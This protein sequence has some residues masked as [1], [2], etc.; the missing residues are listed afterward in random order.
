MQ[1]RFEILAAALLLIFAINNSAWSQE[2]P[3]NER[4]QNPLN[5]QEESLDTTKSN[6][7]QQEEKLYWIFLTTGKSL[8]SV[9]PELVEKMQAEH[10]ANFKQLAEK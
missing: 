8:D 2:P 5:S 1:L 7:D 4:P 9:E 10:L 6:I 3:T